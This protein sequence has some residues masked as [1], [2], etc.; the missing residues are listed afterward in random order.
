MDLSGAAAIAVAVVLML[1]AAGKALR[2]QLFRRALV[3]TYHVRPAFV[4]VV[5]WGVQVAEVACAGLLVVPSSRVSGLLG[6]S[7]LLTGFSAVQAVAWSMGWRG[8]CGCFGI[9]R[10]EALGART[11]IRA[12]RRTV[13]SWLALVMLAAS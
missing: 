12:V 6:S 13:I 11:L 4:P 3:T 10:E 2:Q 9:V 1:S 7:M 5:A 8:D